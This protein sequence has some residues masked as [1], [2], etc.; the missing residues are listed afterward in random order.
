MFFARLISYVLLLSIVSNRK[1]S[2]TVRKVAY[3]NDTKIQRTVSPKKLRK[4]SLRENVRRNMK[5]ISFLDSFDNAP[6]ECAMIAN[7]VTDIELVPMGSLLIDT[8]NNHIAPFK[9]I[10]NGVL[11]RIENNLLI[12]RLSL[13]AATGDVTFGQFGPGS[14]STTPA[15]K[16]QLFSEQYI[17]YGI[18]VN[19]FGDGASTCLMEIRDD[20]VLSPFTDVYLA[21]NND[22]QNWAFCARAVLRL[23]L[24]PVGSVTQSFK[25]ELVFEDICGV[26]V[27][28]RMDTNVFGVSGQEWIN[29]AP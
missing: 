29:V 1:F 9:R 26:T 6:V 12:L 15:V 16:S 11:K 3:N 19:A 27:P 25:F 22:V 14:S 4:E 10:W 23:F 24:N 18:E 20:N 21:Y 17:R 2:R 13:N 7:S 8:A 28:D 5:E